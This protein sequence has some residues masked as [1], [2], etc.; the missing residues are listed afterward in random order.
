MKFEIRKASKSNS[1][2]FAGFYYV[3][4]GG[5]G[6]VMLTSEI[7]TQKHSCIESIESIIENFRKFPFHRGKPYNIIIDATR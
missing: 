3:L 6:E 2:M 1:K 4:I 5:N 7:M